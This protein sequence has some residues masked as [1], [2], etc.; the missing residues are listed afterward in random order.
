MF[1]LNSYTIF[2][3]K[4]QPL[5]TDLEFKYG[6]EGAEELLDYQTLTGGSANT[7]TTTTGTGSAT[8]EEIWKGTQKACHQWTCGELRVAESDTNDPQVAEDYYNKNVRTF[9][10]DVRLITA[11]DRFVDINT[12]AVNKETRNKT[13]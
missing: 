7:T 1:Y 9:S 4:D 2:K 6:P 12:W 13:P 10:N 3:E 11:L 8:E 5:V